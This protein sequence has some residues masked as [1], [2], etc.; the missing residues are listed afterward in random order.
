MVRDTIPPVGEP[1]AIGDKAEEALHRHSNQN[2]RIAKKRHVKRRDVH[3]GDLV[4]VKNRHPG[5]KFRLPFLIEQW[6]VSDMKG[7]MVT[8]WE[9]AETITRNVLFFKLYQQSDPKPESAKDIQVTGQTGND[10]DDAGDPRVEASEPSFFLTRTPAYQHHMVNSPNSPK[11]GGRNDLYIGKGEPREDVVVSHT[12][13][14]GR[15]D[16]RPRP[17]TSTKIKDFVLT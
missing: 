17:A 11:N 15:Y 8:S 10:D 5:S 14:M 6:R 1:S 2:D 16:R 13:G 9:D 3:I 4:L 12:Q 7:T